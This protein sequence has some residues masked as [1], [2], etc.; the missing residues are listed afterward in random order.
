LQDRHLDRVVTGAR[1]F[2]VDDIFQLS[3]H[4]EAQ[5]QP[6]IYARCRLL[7]HACAQHQ[8]VR[9][10]LRLGGGFLEDGQ[11]IAAQTHGRASWL[12]AN[13]AAVLGEKPGRGKTPR[14]PPGAGE[15]AG[16]GREPHGSRGAAHG[17]AMTG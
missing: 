3:Q 6:R 8:P 2:L 1:L 5:G 9:G 15:T 7:D 10:D 14:S 16:S 13:V 11:E 12:G 4:L 17:A